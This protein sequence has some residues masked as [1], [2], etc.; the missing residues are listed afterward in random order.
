MCGFHV[1]FITVHFPA[2]VSDLG[3]DAHVGAYGIAIVG[4]FN[5][6]GAFIAGV[7]GMRFSKKDMLSVI[8]TLRALVITA[9]M[10]APKTELTIYVFA[11]TMGLLWL[12]TV[13]LTTRTDPTGKTFS[14]YSE[15]AW[16]NT[17]TRSPVSSAQ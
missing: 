11:A 13:P 5:I 7:A 1:A 6:V 12:S 9:L 15:R 16:K 14:R 4:L 17:S 10:V 2:Y 3:L 8:Y